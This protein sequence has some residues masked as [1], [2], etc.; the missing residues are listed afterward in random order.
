MIIK[1]TIQCQLGEI[2]VLD[3]AKGSLECKMCSIDSFKIPNK[4]LNTCVCQSG[5]QEINSKCYQIPAGG[6]WSES[7]NTFYCDKDHSMVHH[8]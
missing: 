2:I 5:F 3:E 6:G 7:L 1:E 8:K 4:E